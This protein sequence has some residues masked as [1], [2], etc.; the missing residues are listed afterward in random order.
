MPALPSEGVLAVVDSLLHVAVAG[1][2]DAQGKSG[3]G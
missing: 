2:D 3:F 1:R